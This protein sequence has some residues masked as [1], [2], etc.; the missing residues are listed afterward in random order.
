ME[1]RFLAPA[2]AELEEAVAYYNSQKDGLGFEFSEE[3]RRT[4]GRIVQYPEAWSSLSKRTRRCQTKKFPYGL[5]YHLRSLTRSLAWYDC[6]A[7][8]WSDL[9][10]CA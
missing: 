2:Q 9:S 10:V 1:I 6:P 8:S 7:W 3:I 5:V 4:V